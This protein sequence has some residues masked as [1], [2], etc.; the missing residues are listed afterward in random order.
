MDGRAP[1]ADG[2]GVQGLPGGVVTLRQGW[3]GPLPGAGFSQAAAHSTAHFP[4]RSYKPLRI[5][6]NCARTTDS[7]LTVLRIGR[8]SAADRRRIISGSQAEANTVEPFFRFFLSFQQKRKSQS[9]ATLEVTGE[10]K[11]TIIAAARHRFGS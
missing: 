2:L 7:K 8:G 10:K 4:G 5:N 1:R 3:S 6:T 11:Q 9:R